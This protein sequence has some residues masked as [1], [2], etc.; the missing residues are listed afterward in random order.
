MNFSQK[1][2]HIGTAY[3]L[4]L[5]C[6]L[7]LFG[8]QRFYTGK[9]VSGILYLITFGWFGIGQ[10][11]DLALIPEMVDT[12]NRYSLP[13]DMASQNVSINYGR[14]TSKLS[15]SKLSG[16][17]QLDIHK[18]LRSA[19]A[20]DGTLSLAQAMNST[21]L[22]IEDTKQILMDAE[23]SDLCRTENDEATGHIRYRFDV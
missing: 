20:H 16:E 12:V 11:I 3:A 10:L 5:L 18:L 7:G 1:D 8:C 19:M 4:W 6:L 17:H 21:G 15:H 23:R 2:R 9:Y 13:N 14:L 22:N